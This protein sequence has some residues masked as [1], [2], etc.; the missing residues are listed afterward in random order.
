MITLADGSDTG[1]SLRN[2]A[3]FCAVTGLRTTPGLYLAQDRGPLRALRIGPRLELGGSF[4][5]DD[6]PRVA[7]IS[8]QRDTSNA[9]LFRLGGLELSLGL[10]LTLWFGR[11]NLSQR[12]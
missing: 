2:P 6:G 8:E 11:T 7:G 5:V 1:G 3:S 10:E 4:L 12:P 9:Q